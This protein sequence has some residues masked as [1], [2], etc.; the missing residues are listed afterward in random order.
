M[1]LPRGT[2]DWTNKYGF[3]TI[4]DIKDGKNA[5]LGP[6]YYNTLWRKE[7]RQKS[8]IYVSNTHY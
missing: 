1:A 7:T 8:Q 3:I 5:K 4:R 2:R 6:Q